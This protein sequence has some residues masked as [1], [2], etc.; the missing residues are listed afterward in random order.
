MR[1]AIALGSNLG[2]RLQNLQRARDE[3]RAL[4]RVG[5]PF[6]CS[7]VY[8]TEPVAC[9]PGA[10]TFL[11]AVVELDFNGQ[12]RELLEALLRIEMHLGRHATRERNAPR[13]IDLDLIYFGD[14]QSNAP[15]LTMPH[16]RAHERR[17]VLQPLHELRPDFV[18]PG[19]RESV[20]ALLGKLP[21]SPAVDVFARSW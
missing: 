9:A 4:H 12:P 17:F 18:L 21:P 11:N 10:Q 5:E 15:A 3:L 1:T 20:A 2:G 14:L 19:Q 8:E 7:S 13:T 6:C 16:P